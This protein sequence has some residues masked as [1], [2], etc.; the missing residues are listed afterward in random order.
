M[1]EIRRGVPGT[2]ASELSVQVDGDRLT[3]L[4]GETAATT[5]RLP[6]DADTTAAAAFCTDGL[7]TLQLPKLLTVELPVLDSRHGAE[8]ET[9][10]VTQVGCAGPRARRCE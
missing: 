7:L 5:I 8:V 2:K 6:S 3:I 4:A 1:Y 9:A 10:G